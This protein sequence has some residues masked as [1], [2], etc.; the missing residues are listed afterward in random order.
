M[1]L[2]TPASLRRRLTICAFLGVAAPANRGLAAGAS[3]EAQV[4]LGAQRLDQTA[5]GIPGV[6][7]Q[8]GEF[9]VM[10]AN[11]KHSAQNGPYTLGVA[12]GG[13]AGRTPMGDERFAG[14]T[15]TPELAYE[16]PRQTHHLKFGAARSFDSLGL[17]HDSLRD[18]LDGA[19]LT[20][21][22]K[23]RSTLVR[24][25]TDHYFA[26]TERYSL[27]LYLSASHLDREII[28]KTYFGGG[29]VERDMSPDWRLRVGGSS[30][31]VLY[32]RSEVR[33]TGPEL[34]SITD[35]SP[36]W[37]LTLKL[38]LRH[39]RDSGGKTEA[40]SGGASLRYER[41]DAT[42][43]AGF[44]RQVSSQNVGPA[45]TANDTSAAAFA[46][47]LEGEMV[48]E[49]QIDERR[50]V[51]LSGPDEGSRAETTTEELRYVLGFGGSSL[52]R[53]GRSRSNVVFAARQEDLRVQSGS[54]ASRHALSAAF[55][56]YF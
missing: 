16:G 11:V 35:F 48:L 44:D 17:A 51:W 40:S 22:E 20:E 43:T 26:L 32:D 31:R 6:E 4:S 28:T 15:L 54:T 19:S 41:G 37:Q 55:E 10:N 30:L 33:S 24:V 50:D 39:L 49:G 13:S 34:A 23:Q 5:T 3:S 9:G 45:L 2:G 7:K 56:R 27:V 36:A 52:W 29:Y 46:L 53:P 38:G 12:V 8:H 14:A 47:P 25:G 18:Q 1:P 42:M 21:T